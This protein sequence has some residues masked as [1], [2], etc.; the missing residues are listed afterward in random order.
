MTLAASPDAQAVR[1]TREH[2]A[3]L[4]RRLEDDFGRAGTPSEGV[5]AHQFLLDALDRGEHRA[6]TVWPASGPPHGV[7]YVGAGGLVVPGGLSS[8]AEP[9]AAAVGTSGWRVLVGDLTIGQAVVDAAGSGLF[10]RRPYAREQ[11]LMVAERRTSVRPGPSGLRRADRGDVDVLTEFAC[12]LHVEDQMG[13]PLSRSG[14]SSV[15][16][17]VGNSVRRGSSWVIERDGRVVGKI[18]V[19]IESRRR[20]AQ[21]A[22]VYV[23]LRWRG[24]GLAQRGI[25]E[26]TDRLLADGLPSVT[27]HVRADNAPAIRAYEAAGYV[28]RRRW[29]LALR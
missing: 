7:C 14:R 9:L 22:G 19:S 27:L 26:L 18:D 13:P 15:Q 17:R 4:M 12:G 21:L 24:R 28:Q 3:V 25:A 5:A 8:A 23:D 16:Q 6:M 1:L 29:V 11:R 2:V 10:R 20:G